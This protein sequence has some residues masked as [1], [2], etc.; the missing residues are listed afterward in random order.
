M[1]SVSPMPS[2]AN[3][4]GQRSGAAEVERVDHELHVRIEAQQAGDLLLHA[5]ARDKHGERGNRQLLH[6]LIVHMVDDRDVVQAELLDILLHRAAVV[7]V[8]LDRDDR[9]LARDERGL[10][11]DG[12]A[13]NDA[14]RVV[15]RHVLLLRMTARISLAT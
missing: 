12:L 7:S 14:D 6:A 5:R 8:I 9:S 2:F 4:S 1:T 10:D 3:R 15:G 13:R 11:R